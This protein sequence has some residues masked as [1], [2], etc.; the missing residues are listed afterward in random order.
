MTAVDMATNRGLAVTREVGKVTREKRAFSV[1]IKVNNEKNNPIRTIIGG[2]LNGVN[3]L[4]GD[5][6]A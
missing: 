5:I 1:K 3:L 4:V 6:M 2:H